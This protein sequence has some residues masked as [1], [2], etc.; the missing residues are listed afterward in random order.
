MEQRRNQ[1]VLRQRFGF[2]LFVLLLSTAGS[3]LY[4]VFNS[5][6]PTVWGIILG[7]AGSALVWSFVELF[8]FFVEIYQQFTSERSQFFI[9]TEE[10]WSQLRSIFR[11]DTSIE[12]LPW[13]MVA[14]IVDDLYSKTASFPFQ[15]GI[16]SIS[17]E[18][19]S[20]AIYITR[21][22]WKSH[23]YQHSAAKENT[24]DYW[25]PFYRDFVSVESEVVEDPVRRFADFSH[26][27]DQI[28]ALKEID[29]SFEDF[30]H[31]EGMI[32]H[33]KLGDLGESISIPSGKLQRK[34]LKPAYDFRQKFHE[35]PPHG[36]F[37]SVMGLLFRRIKKW[38]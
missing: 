19:E 13:E 37:I 29:I 12:E 11:S 14:E 18:F 26:I 10:H 34:T 6:W 3:I 23:G 28:D 38:K 8:D 36:A 1:R 16:Y 21:M 27:N 20:A 22:H 15:G 35:S 30:N 2:R 17:D 24:R 32:H 31:P 7:L 25:E 9:M 5:Y 4:G 33:Y